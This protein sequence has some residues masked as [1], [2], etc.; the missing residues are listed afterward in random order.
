MN[1]HSFPLAGEKLVEESREARKRMIFA[2]HHRDLARMHR[3]TAEVCPFEGDRKYWLRQ[4]A[5]E[6]ANAEYH[7]GMIP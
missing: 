4:A 7:E 2:S 5:R 1:A 3:R 6:I